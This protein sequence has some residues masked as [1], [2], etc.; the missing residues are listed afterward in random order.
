MHVIASTRPSIY[1]QYFLKDWRTL[2]K[3]TGACEV[4]SKDVRSF[5]SSLS[6]IEHY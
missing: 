5:L 6:K 1:G 4:A 3:E 2:V